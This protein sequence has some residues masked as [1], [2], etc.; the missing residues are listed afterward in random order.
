MQVR[1]RSAVYTERDM[2]FINFEIIDFIDILVVAIIM[3]QIFRLTR[4]TNALRIVA[5]ILIVYILWVVVRALHM[6]L[7]SLILGQIIGVGVIALL[8]VFQPEVRRF[9]FLL[10]SQYSNRGQTFIGRIFRG[11][12]R[13]ADLEWIDPI[14]DACSD[15]AVTNTGALIVIARNVNLINYIE[16]GQKVDAVISSGLIKSIFFRNSPLHDGAIII[17]D[18]RIAAAKCILPV[19]DKELPIEY[20]TRHRAAIGMA[21]VSDALVVIVS[22][23]RGTIAIAR[24][25]SVRKN[26]TP[27]QLRTFLR[28]ALLIRG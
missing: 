11:K 20:G 10:G 25:G 2:G 16:Q 27:L 9:L 6:E 5:G 1:P 4:G 21:E 3:Y 22:E 14:V 13:A 23:E 28:R 19:T 17:A 8:I 24:K 7:L 12:S 15:M 18:E 26:M